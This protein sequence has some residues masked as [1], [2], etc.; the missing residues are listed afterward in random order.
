M[1]LWGYSYLRYRHLG[2]YFMEPGDYQD[3]SVSKVL[4]FVQNVWLLK[5]WN[6]EAQ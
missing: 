4:H 1:R 2:H 5:C 3:A 6:G